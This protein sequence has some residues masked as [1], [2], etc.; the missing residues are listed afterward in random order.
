M[1]TD[2]LI[3]IFDYLNNIL[4]F[5]NNNIGWLKW[6]KITIVLNKTTM[7]Q[8]QEKQDQTVLKLLV[9]QDLIMLNQ[10]WI[11]NNFIKNEDDILSLHFFIIIY[12]IIFK[13]FVINQL[14]KIQSS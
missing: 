10:I 12:P 5:D 9:M 3:K 2:K 14:L 6:K 7:Q 1:L 4:L 8:T 11:Q 13:L